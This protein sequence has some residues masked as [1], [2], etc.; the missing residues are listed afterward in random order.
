MFPV[1]AR[2]ESGNLFDD[3]VFVGLPKRDLRF[4]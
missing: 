2:I 4:Q 3:E 1:A